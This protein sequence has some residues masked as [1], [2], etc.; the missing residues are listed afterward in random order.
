[1]FYDWGPLVRLFIAHGK[2]AADDAVVDYLLSEIPRRLPQAEVVLSRDAHRTSFN[3]AGSWDAWVREVGAGCNWQGC[4]TFDGYVVP[5]FQIGRRT[6][7]IISYALAVGRPVVYWPL[8][9][10]PVPVRAV[11]AVPG[12]DSW[13]C[14][15]RVIL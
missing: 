7:E 1:M 14:G 3:S 10:D 6:V 2:G 9:G 13:L 8:G 5:T 12:E 11:E 4:P 15:W